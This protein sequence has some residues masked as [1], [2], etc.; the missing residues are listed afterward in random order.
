MV[1]GRG[2]AGNKLP[3]TLAF[4]VLVAAAIGAGC[5]G[6]FTKSVLQ[7]LAVGPAT[8]TIQ[9][10]N[11]GNTQQFTAVGT[12]D[13]GLQVDNKVTWSVAPVGIARISNSG[14]A[15]A[16]AVGQTT[17]TATSTEIPTIFGSTSLTVVPGGVTSITVTPGSQS[18]KTGD[19]FELLA[20]D[21]S[22]ND[23]SASVT[24]TFYLTGTTTQE[25]G[26]T[27]GTPDQGGQPF[28]VGT[29]SPTVTTFPVT[30]DAVASLTI[31]NVTVTSKRVQVQITS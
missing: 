11:T 6:F 5:R 14:L 28:T 27:L 13:T 15:T 4:G 25:T 26:F 1:T 8:Q 22:G 17:V 12:Y 29:L 31:N 16:E 19:T 23:I 21:Q 2:L 20:K 3:L 9:T 18:T 7:S 24:W 30:L 10:G